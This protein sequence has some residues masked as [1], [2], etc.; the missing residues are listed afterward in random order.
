MGLAITR[1]ILI[2]HGGGIEAASAPGRGATFHFWVPL[3]EK[4][5]VKEAVV[6]PISKLSG[7]SPLARARVE[8]PA[9]KRR[10]RGA[11]TAIEDSNETPTGGESLG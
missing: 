10:K 9:A 1:A 3:V 8:G 11:V 2:A 5:P 6:K 4:E 7:Q